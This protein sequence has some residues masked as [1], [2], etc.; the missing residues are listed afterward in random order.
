MKMNGTYNFCRVMLKSAG[1]AML[2]G[3]ALTG[4][5]VSDQTQDK[6]GGK[7][8][9]LDE[10]LHSGRRVSYGPTETTSFALGGNVGTEMTST[11]IDSKTGSTVWMTADTSREEEI[12]SDVSL[13]AVAQSM[14]VQR[15]AEWGIK[16]DEL[17][18][19]SA[20]SHSEVGSYEMIHFERWFEGLPV[21]DSY[22]DVIFS[23]S[24]DQARF[25][26]Q[27][28]MGRH[29]GP[30]T[31]V[32]LAENCAGDTWFVGA[33]GAGAVTDSMKELIL[34]AAS[35][36]GS[37]GQVDYLRAVEVKGTA[38]NH[39]GE[40]LTL[41]FR[42]G[43]GLLLE[44]HSDRIYAAET[45]RMM[46]SVY[47]RS[48]LGSKVD[49]PL[50]LANIAD[51]AQN[52]V[53]DGLGFYTDPDGGA[54]AQ[55][56]LDSARGYVLDGTQQQTLPVTSFGNDG[57]ALVVP[58]GNSMVATNAWMNVQR[59]NAFVRRHLTAAEA[60]ILSAH[61]KI[62]INVA[63]SCN[64]FYTAT[65]VNFFPEGNGCA[66]TALVNDV[67][68]HE[69]GHGLDDYT[70]RTPGIT[71][72]AFSEGIGDINASFMIGDSNMGSG[73][74]LNSATPIR[75]M[76]NTFRFPDNQGEVHQEGQIIGGAFWDMRAAMINRY[77]ASRGAWLAEELFYKHLLTTDTYQDSYQAVL[78]L[79]DNDGNPATPSPDLCLINAA[80]AAHGLATVIANCT[81]TPVAPDLAV[82]SDLAVAI[83]RFDATGVTVLASSLTA[84]SV[85]L[86]LDDVKKCL[87]DTKKI[88]PMK[89]DGSK[90]GRTMFVSQSSAAVVAGTT[91]TA[92]TLDATGKPLAQ[93]SVRIMSR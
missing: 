56:K 67:V 16:A 59:I 90:V 50:P 54:A 41:S 4:C 70:G 13:M 46:A 29:T 14:I 33:A 20:R 57:T 80:F 38:L 76:L 18:T 71:D 81:D 22:F 44:A 24:V 9:Q 28:V 35:P 39:P 48:Y 6:S 78:R 10:A 1:P 42:C 45:R 86:C 72:G 64:A 87:A 5:G 68:Y 34:A 58:A 53:T 63:G 12:D 3:A 37:P 49:L 92:F 82:D 77:G 32:N 51:G 30:I 79:D 84:S 19:H 74:T 31:V 21:R 8:V 75:K 40:K 65:T 88:V 17:R 91:V 83:S 2:I 69:W 60:G 66:N 47:E 11:Q 55:I 89:V 25:K 36:P 7:S 26:F 15:A 43:N 61:V 93:R 62:S 23:R 27:E 85:G 52:F 73:F